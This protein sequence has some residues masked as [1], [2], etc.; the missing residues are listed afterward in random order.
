MGTE[1]LPPNLFLPIK[2]KILLPSLANK[3]SPKHLENKKL[4]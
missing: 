2:Q 3:I 4:V 1:T